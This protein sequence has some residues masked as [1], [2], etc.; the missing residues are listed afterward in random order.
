MVYKKKNQ[1]NMKMGKT[2][3]LLILGNVITVTLLA[4]GIFETSREESSE[5]M[6]QSD[7]ILLEKAI[8][9]QTRQ[10]ETRQPDT[11]VVSKWGKDSATAVEKYSLYLEYYKQKNY[12][13]AYKFWNWLFYHA[14]R[15]NEN[16]YIRGSTLLDYKIL[17]SSG[18]QKDAYVDT[19]MMLYDH[20]IKYFNREGYVL[21]RKGVDI[22]KYRPENYEQAYQVFKRSVELEGKHSRSYVPANYIR[23]ATQM[24]DD[25]KITKDR[26]LEIFQTLKE[27][28]KQ[29][30]PGDPEKW[31]RI[32]ELVSSEVTPYFACSDLLDL[33]RKNFK[34]NKENVDALKEMKN[35]LEAK[36]CTS[37]QLYREISEALY[38]LKP[39]AGFAFQLA[40]HW[41]DQG[42]MG[43]AIHYYTQAIEKEKD[44]KPASDYCIALAQVYKKRKKYKEAKKYAQKAIEL[45]PK[46]G[47]A[48]IFLG[49]LYVSGASLCG[50]DFDKH[51]VYWIAV[52]Q[53]QK[54]QSVDK[55]VAGKAS[56]RIQTYSEAFPTKQKVFFRNLKE[57]DTY[58][59][60]CWI[61]EKT[62]VRVLAEK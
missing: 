24:L 34:E 55:S 35:V 47:K 19:L 46:S 31:Q 17:N 57:G 4:C 36:E 44:G 15:V 56:Q 13:Y 1:I 29:N 16:L 61:N 5:K 14:P 58:T 40:R 7:K 18:A 3:L 26:L 2:F 21:G 39:T 11:G 30:K 23:C 6:T 8:D 12:E 54:A 62:T 38:K 9:K 33:Y 32:D 10:S 42:N 53:Y 59:V 45:N 22:M 25:G 28:I 48:Y 52:D 20:R 60:K 27:I 43:K 51:T 50:E 49:D 41:E 37:D